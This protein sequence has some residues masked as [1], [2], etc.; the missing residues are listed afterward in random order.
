MPKRTEHEV[1]DI[2]R[3]IRQ[4]PI[5]RYE[6]RSGPRRFPTTKPGHPLDL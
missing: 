6:E 2:E 3:W 4:F 5:E 1:V